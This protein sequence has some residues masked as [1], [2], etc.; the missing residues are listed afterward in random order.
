M[1]RLLWLVFCCVA[2]AVGAYYAQPYTGHNSDAVLIIATVFSVFAGFL[3]AVITIIGD[4]VMIQEGSWRIAEVGHDTMR[5]RLFAHIVLFILY[6]FTIAL[7]FVGVILEKALE[8]PYT[9][10]SVVEWCYLF[11]GIT[12]FLLTL[13]LPVSL[14][15]MQKAR[16]EAEI[17]R[18]RAQAGIPS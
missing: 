12:S 7:L 17:E 15:N 13:A 8:C 1:K 16:Y 6:L 14:W 5:N 2:G 18:R 10:K 4:P 11:L 3:I 9:I